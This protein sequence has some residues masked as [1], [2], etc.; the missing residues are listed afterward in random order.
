MAEAIKTKLEGCFMICGT[1]T[2]G[3]TSSGVSTVVTGLNR[4]LCVQVSYSETGGTADLYSTKSGG[5]VTITGT[6]TIDVDYT[7]IGI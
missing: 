7:I 5:T 1:V 3:S 2:L 4:V 6:N